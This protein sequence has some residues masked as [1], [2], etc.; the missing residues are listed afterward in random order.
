MRKG[1]ASAVCILIAAAQNTWSHDAT[2]YTDITNKSTQLSLSLSPTSATYWDG[3]V[4]NL[5]VTGYGYDGSAGVGPY[6]MLQIDCLIDGSLVGNTS[7][8]WGYGQV[9]QV[10][11]PIQLEGLSAGTHTVTVQHTNSFE[12][13][14]RVVYLY[15]TS[16]TSWGHTYFHY[17]YNRFHYWTAPC[18]ASRT[19]TVNPSPDLRKLQMSRIDDQL[20][21]TYT[22]IPTNNY[23]F[24]FSFDLNDWYLLNVS[25]TSTNGLVRFYDSTECGTCFYRVY[26]P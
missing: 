25:K 4:A 14:Q 13:F 10:N 7:F 5:L 21:F 18:E 22:G 16:H 1:I 17:Y 24:Y 12:Y 15:T 26:G 2:Y 20:T 23:G 6:A 11:K 9:N 8:I 19:L 3:S